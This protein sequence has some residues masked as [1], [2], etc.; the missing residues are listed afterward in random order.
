[1]IILFADAERQPQHSPPCAFTYGQCT[2]V[3]I[4]H[5]SLHRT[6]PGN[7]SERTH[8]DRL[9]GEARGLASSFLE[10]R[11]SSQQL[12]NPHKQDCRKEASG[13]IV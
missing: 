11:I 6:P 13:I 4:S 2:T 5:F 7:G 3:S 1:M 9:I 8:R 12:A 10:F